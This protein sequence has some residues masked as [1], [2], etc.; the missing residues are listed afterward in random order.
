MTRVALKGLL[1]RKVR[2]ALTALAVVLGV[3]MVSGSFVLTDTISKAFTSIFTAA[4]D[5]TDAVVSG[6]KLVDFSSSGNATVSPALLEKI[7]NRPDVTAAAGS[8]IDLNGD[9]TRANLIGKDGKAISNAG[10]PTFGLGIDT[11]QPRFNPLTLKRRMTP[12]RRS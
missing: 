1:G 11:S 9:S 10:A 2:A 6:R 3:A 7:R 8:I 4:Y 5:H 12:T